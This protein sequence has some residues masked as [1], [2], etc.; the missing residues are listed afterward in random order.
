MK[1]FSI[2]T[3][4]VKANIE[5]IR[6]TAQDCG[7]RIA[8]KFFSDKVFF[9]DDCRRT[10][11]GEELYHGFVFLLVELPWMPGVHVRT[12]G[13]NSRQSSVLHCPSRH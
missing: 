11:D 13:L 6:R 5:K 8:Y 12:F 10:K 7:L 4:Q 9:N 3:R 2:F 1:S